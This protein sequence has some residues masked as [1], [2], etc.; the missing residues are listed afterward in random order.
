MDLVREVGECDIDQNYPEAIPSFNSWWNSFAGHVRLSCQG[1]G[2]LA[3][4][5]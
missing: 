2:V 5:I 4:V 1:G 3:I